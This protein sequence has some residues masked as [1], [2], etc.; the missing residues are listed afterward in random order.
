MKFLEIIK[1]IFNG[2]TKKLNIDYI[3]IGG[4]GFGRSI[5][6]W[7]NLPKCICGGYPY[8]VGKKNDCSEDYEPNKIYC[9]KCGKTTTWGTVEDIRKEWIEMNLSED[10][11]LRR[12]EVKLK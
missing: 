2:K 6:A 1:N 4:S 8:M 7:D 9:L 5:H 12:E 3:C 10:N 11:S